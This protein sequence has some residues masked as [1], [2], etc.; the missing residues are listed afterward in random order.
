MKFPIMIIT[1]KRW[2]E[3]DV[4]AERTEQHISTLS[5]RIGVILSEMASIQRAVDALRSDVKN[6]RRKLNEKQRQSWHGTFTGNA[7]SSR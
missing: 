5:Q 3:M 7:A 6:I 1:R 4:R 2:R